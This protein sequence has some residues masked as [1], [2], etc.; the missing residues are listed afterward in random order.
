M[1]GIRLTSGTGPIGPSDAPTLV[2]L[3]PRVPY[4]SFP[5]NS[6]EKEAGFKRYIE[7]AL[8]NGISLEGLIKGSNEEFPVVRATDEVF[9]GALVS[10]RW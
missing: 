1:G 8:E 3:M 7:L 4:P 5:L 6:Y 10:P 9:C 2:Q